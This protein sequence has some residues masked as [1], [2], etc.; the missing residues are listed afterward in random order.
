MTVDEDARNKSFPNEALRR[1]IFS[2]EE[3]SDG[4]LSDYLSVTDIDLEY[5]LKLLQESSDAVLQDL[6]IGLCNRRLFKQVK[7]DE[8]D[9]LRGILDKYKTS[10]YYT[11]RIEIDAKT[12]GVV[13]NPGKKEIVLFDKQGIGFRLSEKSSVV[14]GYMKASVETLGYYAASQS[15]LS[16]KYKHQEGILPTIS[17]DINFDT[18][19]TEQLMV[20]TIEEAA[21]SIPEE[22]KLTPKVGA[23]LCNF[24]GNVL[25]KSFRGE[26]G[27]GT[28]CEYSLLEKAKETEIDFKQTVLFVTLEPCTKRGEDKIPCAE[29][30]V[31]A[32]IPIVF[33]G[34]TDP[35]PDFRDIGSRYLRDNGVRVENYPH[36]FVEII[37]IMNKDFEQSFK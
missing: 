3:F 4:L 8:W 25:L 15:V 18:T 36:K 26:K 23:L 30:I 24:K 22:G 1:I 37:R 34:M 12:E 10:D 7:K 5:S 13:Y 29:R 9:N 20:T 32:G 11:A 19:L 27:K 33:M 28:H 17:S 35:N 2:N 16:D 31:K 21:K 6:A 14:T